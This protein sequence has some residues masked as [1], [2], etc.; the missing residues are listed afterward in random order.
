MLLQYKSV[1]FNVF[2][3]IDRPLYLG[4]DKAPLATSHEDANEIQVNLNGLG[5]YDIDLSIRHDVHTKHICNDQSGIQY[6]FLAPFVVLQ[7]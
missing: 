2:A 7:Y 4:Y 1:N 3:Q 6:A 5:L